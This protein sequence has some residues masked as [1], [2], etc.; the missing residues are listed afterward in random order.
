MMREFANW[1]LDTAKVRGASYA[2]ARVMDI[3]LR[4]LS[5]KNGQVGTL[6]ESESYGIGIRVIAQGSW[7]FASTDR[8]T[9]EGIAAC[10]AE[11]VAIAKASALAKRHD[12]EMVPVNAYQDTWQNPYIKD[13]FQIP[14]ERQLDHLLAADRAMSR[15]KGV[16][17]SEA[18]MTF[19]GIE[20]FFASSIGSV[21]H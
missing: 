17:V 7:G 10:A 11:A 9:R 3:R 4:D 20:Q 18:S 1:A 21:F 14:I 2:D 16:T 13:P 19:R 5:T 12:V 6:S 8:L 15:V